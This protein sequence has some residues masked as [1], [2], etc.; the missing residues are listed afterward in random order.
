MVVLGALTNA[1]IEANGGT[2]VDYVSEDDKKPS[3]EK[4]FARAL[5]ELGLRRYEN[6]STRISKISVDARHKDNVQLVCSVAV[7]CDEEEKIFER[8]KAKNITLRKI[9]PDKI[10][11]LKKPPETRPVIIGFGPAGMFAGLTLARAGYR[12]ILI[13]PAP[14]RNRLY[15][16]AAL[17][18]TNAPQPWK[19]IGAAENCAPMQTYS[20]ARE[21]RAPSATE[22][23]PQ[24]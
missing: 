5:S 4:A 10:P 9:A 14:A 21:E 8:K 20:S 23:L 6:V 22:S 12:P 24:G 2:I 3:K 13:L 15:L 11:A 19:N 17:K 7:S 18:L 16:N 1:I